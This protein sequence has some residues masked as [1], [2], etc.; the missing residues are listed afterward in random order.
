MTRPSRFSPFLNTLSVLSPKFDPKNLLALYGKRPGGHWA[1][2]RVNVARP[3][4]YGKLTPNS[5]GRRGI[6][7][8]EAKSSTSWFRQALAARLARPNFRAFEANSKWPRST[9]LQKV[10]DLRSVDHLI[11]LFSLSPINFYKWARNGTQKF[12]K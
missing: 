2:F 9:S 8:S 4:S 11:R 3:V 1:T 10:A 7:L 12:D 5:W 6:Q